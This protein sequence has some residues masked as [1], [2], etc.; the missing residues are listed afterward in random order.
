ML[1]TTVALASTT[2]MA[3]NGRW[4]GVR[5]DTQFVGKCAEPTRQPWSKISSFARLTVRELFQTCAKNKRNSTNK[6]IFAHSPT[7]HARVLGLLHQDV[8]LARRIFRCV[9]AISNDVQVA[10]GFHR[11]DKTLRQHYVK[12]FFVLPISC[13]A[14]CRHPIL[15]RNPG[16]QHKFLSRRLHRFLNF[17]PKSWPTGSR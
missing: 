10:H 1:T 3:F 13:K 11:S 6:H 15:S 12:R 5:G 14:T 16:C 4:T 9:I 7:V 17:D 2:A 8:R